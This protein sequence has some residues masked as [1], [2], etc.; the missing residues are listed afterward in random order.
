MGWMV[1]QI[2]ANGD[3]RGIYGCFMPTCEKSLARRFFRVGGVVKVKPSADTGGWGKYASC[4]RW[5]A[6]LSAEPGR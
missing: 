4:M 6:V 2:F 1:F 5:Y 3:W